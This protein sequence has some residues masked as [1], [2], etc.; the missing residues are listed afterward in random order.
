[1]RPRRPAAALVVLLTVLDAASRAAAA[2]G[3]LDATQ[4][5][6]GSGG[7]NAT[8]PPATQAQL[9]Q[10]AKRC[11]VTFP[12]KA[13]D[14]ST[15]CRV[16]GCLACK[17]GGGGACLCCEAGRSLS[18]GG[19]S[20]TQCPVGRF[21]ERPGAAKACKRCTGGTT[22]AKPGSTSCPVCVAGF[23]FVRAGVCSP[24]ARG[25][26]SAGAGAAQD[27]APCPPGFTTPLGKRGTSR[28]LCT[29][30]TVEKCTDLPRPVTGATWPAKCAGG[31][32]CHA[33]CSAGFTGGPVSAKCVSG[34]W[35]LQPGLQC[36]EKGSGQ[37]TLLLS[38]PQAA[39]GARETLVFSVDLTKSQSR[40]AKVK[41]YASDTSGRLLDVL[42]DLYDDGKPAHKD[43]A[44]GDGVFTNVVRTKLGAAGVQHY[45][46]TVT[47]TGTSYTLRIALRVVQPPSRAEA[48]A[49]VRDA[50][51]QQEQIDSLLG[52][53]GSITTAVS[54]VAS[55]L[56]AQPEVDS[57]EDKGSY[58]AWSTTA[59]LGFVAGKRTSIADSGV[60]E[61]QLRRAAEA[62]G[63]LGGSS[64][65]ASPQ[66]TANVGPCKIA[67]GDVMLLSPVLTPLHVVISSILIANGYNVTQKCTRD[68]CQVLGTAGGGMNLTDWSG[69][70]AFNL[71]GLFTDNYG[72]DFLGSSVAFDA[73]DPAMIAHATAGRLAVDGSTGQA[74]LTPQWFIDMWQ[75]SRAPA[76][77]DQVVV[78]GSLSS[79]SPDSLFPAAM[80][81]AGAGFFAGFTTDNMTPTSSAASDLFAFLMQLAM[82]G[83]VRPPTSSAAMSTDNVLRLAGAPRSSAAAPAQTSA[84][85]QF[86]VTPLR[87]DGVVEVRLIDR[88]ECLG[89]PPNYL[90]LLNAAGP[91]PASC[92]GADHASFCEIACTDRFVGSYRAACDSGQWRVLAASGCTK[93]CLKA[94]PNSLLPSAAPAWDA[95][96]AKGTQNN[97]TCSA[98][99]VNREGFTYSGVAQALC[100]DGAWS[101]TLRSTCVKTSC[102]PDNGV[103]FPAPDKTV[104][105]W[106]AC[107]KGSQ[108]LELPAG[109]QCTAACQVPYDGGYTTTCKDGAW[110]PVTGNCSIATCLG[111][112]E[113]G[114]SP[115][116][117]EGWDR[118]CRRGTEYSI[119]TAKC[120]PGFTGGYT[121]QCTAS[122]WAARNGSCTSQQV[123][124]TDPGRADQLTNSGGWQSSC[125]NGSTAGTE[126]I[127]PCSDGYFGS[128]RSTC[129]ADGT[130]GPLRGNCSTTGCT[131]GVTA[132]AP[133]GTAGWSAVCGASTNATQLY[134]SG[135]QCEAACAPGFQGK[136]T[137]QCTS[138]GWSDP[139]GACQPNGCYSVP[140][141]PANSTGFSQSCS[142]AAPGTICRAPCALG[143]GGSYSVVCLS[144]NTW[145]AVTGGCKPVTCTGPPPSPPGG[146]NVTLGWACRNGIE[147]DTCRAACARGFVGSFRS[148]C[149]NSSWTPPEGSCTSVSC[150][151]PSPAIAPANTTG[152]EPACRNASAL[153]LF[154][155]NC[156][157][158][159]G[160]GF[161]GTLT[162]TCING[163][164]SA[165]TPAACTKAFCDPISSTPVPALAS[166]WDPGCDAS[167]KLPGDT[168]SAPCGG[169]LLGQY[170]ATC[171]GTSWEVTGG[172]Y[173]PTANV[174]WPAS[175]AGLGPGAVCT[176]QCNTG[177]RGSYSAT[178]SGP[179]W[180]AASGSCTPACPGLPSARP[181]VGTV[182]PAACNNALPT[183][184]CTATCA[185]GYQPAG[186]VLASTCQADLTWSPLTGSACE[187]VLTG[188]QCGVAGG[189]ITEYYPLP[190][191]VAFSQGYDCT[192]GVAFGYTCRSPCRT[193]LGLTF[194]GTGSTA[195]C[196]SSNTFAVNNSDCTDPVDGCNSSNQC[197]ALSGTVASTCRDV[198]L[199]SAAAAAAA[200]PY[201][202]RCATAWRSLEPTPAGAACKPVLALAVGSKAGA[203]AVLAFDGTGWREIISE[204]AVSGFTGVRLQ[205]EG[206]ALVAYVVGPASPAGSSN[207]LLFTYVYS[208]GTTTWAAAGSP[209]TVSSVLLNDVAAAW[210]SASATARL[211]AA[212]NTAAVTATATA[213][214]NSS[215]LGTTAFTG[216]GTA[217]NGLN[218]S[219]GYYW[220]AGNGGKVY[221]LPRGGG[222][223]AWQALDLPG[224]GDMYGVAALSD[225]DVW[226]VGDL[227]RIARFNGLTGTWAEDGAF[228]SLPYNPNNA[229]GLTLRSISLYDW[230]AG[231][232]VGLGGALFTKTTDS[233]PWYSDAGFGTFVGGRSTNNPDMYGVKLVD[234]WHVIVVGQQIL[235]TAV[236]NSDDSTWQ[237]AE[238]SV[239]PIDGVSAPAD[240]S[241]L[242]FVL[243]AVDSVRGL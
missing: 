14:Y 65:R 185:Q 142:G 220:A 121:A 101:P 209:V 22:N 32:S 136:V 3:G 103:A 118:A 227:C 178:C 122:G 91:W 57:V 230:R 205:R 46:A 132:A 113:S 130:W 166:G 28:A 208:S 98:A 168:C 197:G 180:G 8:Q 33:A 184:A 9:D 196:A 176:A 164:W 131:G 169:G 133:N 154:G 34:A 186:L 56:Q 52:Q 234:P 92:A 40:G 47:G 76:P 221:R 241:A 31:V 77:S 175:C 105:W 79:T 45:A 206:A 74:A 21:L 173:A 207:S 83:S 72:S 111:L 97:A 163:T 216:L 151:M 147:G 110:T 20:C 85:S 195:T 150:D 117:S 58:V 229:C 140:D 55:V 102:S 48:R 107:S 54:Q 119:C 27:C 218:A 153:F 124:A 99:C 108:V 152:W 112:P 156:S 145:S 69:L 12:G 17:R 62:A 96:C 30:P 232:A 181:P 116:N 146:A 135:Y 51:A 158:P 134:E 71:V 1:M 63:L 143:F 162:S 89:L 37:G 219:A 11:R 177:F 237:W 114:A 174:A 15:T 50:A 115:P 82:G 4:Q 223:T 93:G 49:G 199:Q 139:F 191:P 86:V 224:Y 235:A 238:P 43:V 160:R 243:R 240:A 194:S 36:S 81:T 225:N 68:G 126:C 222:A 10:A 171:R 200:L 16:E 23:K 29:V 39:A 88:C 7:G 138:A 59:G 128:Y 215:A 213:A 165:P 217:V 201:T 90:G 231:F 179:S 53:G 183:T 80:S 24:C 226:A 141:A 212:G 26:Y 203:G 159:C 106:E 84:D 35:Q 13:S 172:C 182:W 66:D 157:A 94:P 192:G 42:A 41:L 19:R 161:N 25:S 70:S 233:G 5:A 228:Y 189:G 202:C 137:S 67:R 64:S 75:A 242:G 188:T 109:F 239:T 38:P 100:V 129:A 236:R 2:D 211:L 167:M 170:T 123:C 198:P 6:G 187:A 44:K 210:D 148:Q 78:F 127:A 149:I 87:D 95:S 204:T 60:S 214:A 18:A 193:D 120:S 104:G 144:D 190:T 155:W 125:R 61:A 73:T